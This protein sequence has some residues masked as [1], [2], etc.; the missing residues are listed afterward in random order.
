MP[1]QTLLQQVTDTSCIFLQIDRPSMA[2]PEFLSRWGAGRAKSWRYPR[3]TQ[4]RF[5]VLALPA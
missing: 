1:A 5:I 4:D 3:R 2:D